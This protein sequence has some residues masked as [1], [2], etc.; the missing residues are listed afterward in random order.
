MLVTL[1]SNTFSIPTQI[2]DNEN[3]TTAEIKRVSANDVVPVVLEATQNIQQA[4]ISKR[5]YI[6]YQSDPAEKN[7]IDLRRISEVSEKLN[8]ATG[9]FKSDPDYADTLIGIGSELTEL[10]PGT[11]IYINNESRIIKGLDLIGNKIILDANI[12]PIVAKAPLYFVT[13]LITLQ[14]P[15]GEHWNDFPTVDTN[16]ILWAKDNNVRYI[17]NDVIEFYYRLTSARTD[18]LLTDIIYTPQDDINLNISRLTFKNEVNF[19]STRNLDIFNPDLYIHEAKDIDGEI[20][21]LIFT[22]KS[23]GAGEVLS[24]RHEMNVSFA[25]QLIKYRVNISNIDGSGESATDWNLHF[26]VKEHALG[27]RFNTNFQTI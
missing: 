4:I 9:F 1:T 26:D 10:N 27:Q 11:T 15:R 6:G 19:E 18:L 21:P 7:S 20:S 5:N 22:Y 17:T 8:L 2:R 13:F 14:N 3:G 25:D 24:I 16:T 12:E 23:Q